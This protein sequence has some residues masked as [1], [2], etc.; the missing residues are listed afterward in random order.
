MEKQI[1]LTDMYRLGCRDA[2]MNE[3]CFPLRVVLPGKRCYEKKKKLGTDFLVNKKE[4]KRSKKVFP[5]FEIYTT[6]S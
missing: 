4:K 1:L 2:N 5:T 6:W 3:G